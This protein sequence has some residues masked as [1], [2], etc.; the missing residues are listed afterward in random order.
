MPVMLIFIFNG[1]ASGLSY[2]YFLANVITFGQM[3][4]FRYFINE[5]ALRAK[6]EDKKKRP[7]KPSK[8]QEKMKQLAEAQKKRKK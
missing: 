3:F 7:V 2:Y 6:I 5:D 1:F 4:L 8:W